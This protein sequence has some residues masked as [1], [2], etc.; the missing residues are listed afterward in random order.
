MNNAGL[1]NLYKSKKNAACN[2]DLRIGPLTDSRHFTGPQGPFVTVLQLPDSIPL[3]LLPQQLPH[4]Y[5][6][7][8]V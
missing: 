2:T 4:I 8:R 7:T 6:P 5:I 1:G 3:P